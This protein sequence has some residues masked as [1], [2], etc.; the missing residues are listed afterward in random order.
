MG[1]DRPSLCR[2]ER[3]RRICNGCGLERKLE[4][5]NRGLLEAGRYYLRNT[6]MWLFQEADL[7]RLISGDILFVPK[8]HAIPPGPAK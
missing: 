3:A 2:G 4:F 8:N 5:D 7:S 1:R 6:M